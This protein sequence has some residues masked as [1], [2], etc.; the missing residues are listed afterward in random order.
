MKKAGAIMEPAFL[1]RNQ[2]TLIAC[3]IFDG[4][5]P[6]ELAATLLASLVPSKQLQLFFK[7]AS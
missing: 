4:K 3:F 2:L 6:Y 1:L 7:S 5:I